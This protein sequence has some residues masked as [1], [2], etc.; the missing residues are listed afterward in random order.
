M[1]LGYLGPVLVVAASGVVS[2]PCLAQPSTGTQT[3][4]ADAASVVVERCVADHERAATLRSGP[5]WLEARSALTACTSE[6]CPLAIRSDCSAWLED[7][8]KLVPSI[9]VIVERDDS[10][11][12][13]V[14]LELDDKP[15]E[16]SDPPAPIEVL[17]GT[18]RMRVALVSYAPVERELTLAPGEKNKVVRVQFFHPRTSLPAPAPPVAER[19]WG[20]P[21]PVSTY[22]LS[23]SALA[24]FAASGALLASALVS[25]SDAR[26]TCRPVCSADEAG[27]IRTR[28]VA[29]DFAASVG[30]VLSGLALY[31]YT[32]RP[33]VELRGWN[34]VPAVAIDSRSA[35]L[36]F[37]GEF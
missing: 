15:I 19:R 22:A 28:L 4:S 11:G 8:V 6:A 14:R 34:L 3:E 13:P 5:Q 31:T 26:D 12:P 33:T 9:L 2:P 32:H 27:S 35:G 10:G 18:H 20:R 24:A 17:P 7:L 37:E 36:R 1:R 21:V 23:G 16:L 29:A 30:V 25:R